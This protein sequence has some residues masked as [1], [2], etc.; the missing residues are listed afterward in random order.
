[1]WQRLLEGVRALTSWIRPP[2]PYVPPDPP[3]RWRHRVGRNRERET[4]RIDRYLLVVVRTHTSMDRVLELLE[5]VGEGVSLAIKFTVE[6]GSQF[7]RELVGKLRALGAEEIQW[8][9]A[10][11]LHWD[12][13][14][15][16]H[17]DGQLAEL[18]KE[19]DSDIFVIAHG[20]GYNRAR[21]AS[22]G[23]RPGAAGLSSH[24]LAPDGTTF[25]SLLGLSAPEQR[26]RLCD[27]A[28]GRD[29][30]IGDLVLDKLV[31]YLRHR[32]RFRR[33]LG[34]GRRKLIVVSSTWGPR[35]TYA[36]QLKVVT[37]LVAD[38]SA[39]EY[40][41]ALVLHNNIW[42]GHSKFE[43]RLHL[44]NEI[45][46]GLLI[47]E[48]GTWQ[49]ALVSADLV[50]GDHGS[51][52]SGYAVGLGLPVLIA[53]DGRA[54][55]D[56]ASP[57]TALHLALPRLDVAKPLREQVDRAIAENCPERWKHHTDRVFALR[58][59]G[60]K[61]AANALRSLL[62]LPLFT[63]N[64]RVGTMALPS[65][66]ER[67]DV[68]AHQVVVRTQADGTQRIER[69][70]AILKHAEEFL[71]SCLVISDLEADPTTRSNAEIVVQAEPL[72]DDEA[73]EWIDAQLPTTGLVATA[74]DSGRTLLRFSDGER[75]TVTRGDPYVA[76]ILL[77]WRRTNVLPHT[78]GEFVV[79]LG[80]VTH[81]VV[82]S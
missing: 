5:V 79:A 32:P 62:D 77:H 4:L 27:E 18:Q 73:A 24:E 44:R 68:T 3:I 59:E 38:L 29:I 63:A 65:V 72:P 81:T 64:P 66:V 15:A 11:E 75:I 58:G 52:T 69:H 12:A 49:S 2:C 35:S 48:P 26:T 71:D 80:N 30:V 55:L 70:P 60:L 1:M 39:D 74:T 17:A 31:A 16:A 57:Y 41:V 20:A 61:A 14:F 9:E 47:I 76:A 78:G 19:F 25:V 10:C 40:V 36:T 45:Q 82:A 23:G 28:R 54:E 21:L 6:I 7:A 53:A 8:K 22:T 42:Y 33:E 13:I 34:V 46:S 37:R 43:V 51:V 56:P 67:H 50:V